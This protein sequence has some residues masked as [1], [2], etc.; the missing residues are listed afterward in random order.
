[1]G[2]YQF[3]HFDLTNNLDSFFFFYFQPQLLHDLSGILKKVKEAGRLLNF[4]VPQDDKENSLVEEVCSIC[5]SAF[6]TLLFD[7]L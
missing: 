7:F 3:K 5:L 4:F 6:K 1:M 2:V